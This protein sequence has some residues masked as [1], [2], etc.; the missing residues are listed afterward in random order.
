MRDD[1]LAKRMFQAGAV[2]LLPLLWMCNTLY[3]YDRVYGSC[4]KRNNS[5]DEEG[6][7]PSQE[8]LMSNQANNATMDGSSPEAVQVDEDDDDDSTDDGP[9]DEEELKKWVKRSSVGSLV[10]IGVIITWACLVQLEKGNWFG[11][12][13]FVMSED[14]EE[15]SGW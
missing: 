1:V 3:F 2:M 11:P 9:V 15:L 7:S 4:I 13:W 6:S 8:E 10:S 12:K 14:E 5:N